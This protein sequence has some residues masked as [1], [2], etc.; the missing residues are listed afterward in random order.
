[1]DIWIVSL[2]DL[3]QILG[4]KVPLDPLCGGLVTGSKYVNFFREHRK[5]EGPIA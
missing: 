3:I 1:M 4:A 2:Y 5:N